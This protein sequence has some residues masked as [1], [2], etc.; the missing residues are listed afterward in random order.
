M[1]LKHPVDRYVRLRILGEGGFGV[2]FH[3]HCP[4]CRGEVALKIIK[5]IDPEA[6]RMALRE[7]TIL[8][9]LRHPHVV[10][11]R[12]FDF[13][14]AEPAIVFE[15][16]SGGN[17]IEFVRAQSATAE[18][19]ASI[20][21]SVSDALGALHEAGGFHRDVKPENILLAAAGDQVTVKLA[22]FG[23][24]RLPLPNDP[25]TQT[26]MGTRSYMAP[27]LLSGSPYSP[28]ADIYSLGMTGVC[29]LTGAPQAGRLPAAGCPP[30][31]KEILRA[32][33]DPIP[34]A[35]PTAGDVL[36][37]LRRF[38]VTPP[39]PRKAPNQYL[40]YV[41]YAAALAGVVGAGAYA[42]AE[43]KK[44][45]SRLQAVTKK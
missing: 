16:C 32:M 36:A 39:V 12:D 45:R 23:L 2:V 13:D 25:M 41:G 38:L 18:D 43:A 9:K 34:S 31:L 19:V 11:V 10:R 21:A 5:G 4:D 42:I 24:A 17:A 29:L 28:A 35:R 27:E 20:L 1:A 37:D 44:K 3:A 30:A 14:R 7:V 8:Q 40:K 15:Y 33:I 22:D 6:R 26:A